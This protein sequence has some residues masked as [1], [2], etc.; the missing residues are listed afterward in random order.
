MA[1]ACLPAKRTGLAGRRAL[2]VLVTN[3][4]TDAAVTGIFNLIMLDADEVGTE[5]VVEGRC[6]VDARGLESK[7]DVLAFA[8]GGDKM[9]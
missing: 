6:G 5:R 9:T 1:T 3:P 8:D 7:V 2:A 4:E